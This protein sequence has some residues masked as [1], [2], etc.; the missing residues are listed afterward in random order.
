MD[1]KINSKYNQ[2]RQSEANQ[3]DHAM[4]DGFKKAPQT[5]LQRLKQLF[6]KGDLP[7]SSQTRPKTPNGVMD[8]V[9]SVEDSSSKISKP[10][11]GLSGL[12]EEPG[13]IKTVTFNFLEKK[14]LDIVNSWSYKSPSKDGLVEFLKKVDKL[15]NRG[16]KSVIKS[17]INFKAAKFLTKLIELGEPFEDNLEKKLIHEYDFLKVQNVNPLA[18]KGRCGIKYGKVQYINDELDVADMR[19]MTDAITK[20]LDTESNALLKDYI[21]KTDHVSRDG[22]IEFIKKGLGQIFEKVSVKEFIK[23]DDYIIPFDDLIKRR[24]PSKKTEEV[25]SNSDLLAGNNK[26]LS[27][28][29]KVMSLM[30]DHP[31]AKVFVSHGRSITQ[32]MGH[33]GLVVQLKGECHCF[34]FNSGGQ[35]SIQSINE[36]QFPTEH[37]F[38]FELEVN[39]DV[40]K[41]IVLEYL[42]PTHRMS[43]VPFSI[44]NVVWRTKQTT[45]ENCSSYMAKVLGKTTGF[46]PGFFRKVSYWIPFYLSVNVNDKWKDTVNSINQSSR[47]NFQSADDVTL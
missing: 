16:V 11:S 25:L 2:T 21:E 39:K 1:K 35:F 38:R 3:N 6:S 29:K 41:A 34:D 23:P 45:S 42:S 36:S 17:A 33:I 9:E 5:R 32:T 24:T 20:S 44:R 7:S 10:T 31:D 46:K 12:A 47:R 4:P 8:I 30:M 43:T 14:S 19:L 28:A 15:D 27:Y 26:A 18:N 40:K 37:T 13:P 22:A